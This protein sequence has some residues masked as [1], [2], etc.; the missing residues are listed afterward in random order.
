[1]KLRMTGKFHWLYVKRAFLFFTLCLSACSF[2]KSMDRNDRREVEERNDLIQ[3][4]SL[5]VGTYEGT[6]TDQNRTWSVR[7]SLDIV[8]EPNGKNSNGETIMRPV[9]KALFKRLNPIGAS[10]QYD[11]R[12]QAET[13]ALIMSR[14]SAA[15]SDEDIL[16]MNTQFRDG[17]IAGNAR[18]EAGVVGRLNLRRASR[19]VKAPDLGDDR[20][21]YA[22]LKESY[23]A[24]AGEYRGYVEPP[25]SEA[26]PFA[27]QLTLYVTEKENAQKVMVPYL[28]AYYK[29]LDGN[30]SEINIVMTVNFESDVSPQKLKMS[31]NG[32]GSSAGMSVFI[33]AQLV[34][35]A[36]DGSHTNQMGQTAQVHLV[37]N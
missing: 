13:G 22:R 34:G 24:I 31:G 7:L 1:M 18:S 25:K 20:D 33:E 4:F 15:P 36:L 16:S 3:R 32:T 11:A 6:L 29:R 9:L 17:Q 37:K 27:V 21:Y 5:V 10:Q 30:F 28:M 26:P 14:N 12:F 35:N 8:D 19:D 2:D 23:L